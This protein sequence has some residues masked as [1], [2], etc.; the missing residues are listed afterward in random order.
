MH[1][2]EGQHNV[3]VFPVR[4]RVLADTFAH[5]FCFRELLP[6]QLDVFRAGVEAQVL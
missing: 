1:D 4:K 6:R 3:E 5:E 2:P